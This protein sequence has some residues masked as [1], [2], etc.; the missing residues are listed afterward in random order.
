MKSE[1]KLRGQGW[2]KH[3]GARSSKC[4]IFHIIIECILIKE[5]WFETDKLSFTT[6]DFFR[7]EDNP[8]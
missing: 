6:M 3:L 4:M 2:M 8:T 5:H 1:T 7:S